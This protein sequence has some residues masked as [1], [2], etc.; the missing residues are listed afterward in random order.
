[1]ATANQ[2]LKGIRKRKKHKSKSPLLKG[3]PQKK[4]VALGFMILNLKS[5]T[6]HRD[7]LQSYYFLI[8]GYTINS[9]VRIYSGSRL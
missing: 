1:M 7:R 2:L 6:V 4:G 5:Q 9:I 8:K 3:N